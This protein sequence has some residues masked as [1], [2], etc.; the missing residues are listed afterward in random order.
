MAKNLPA[1]TKSRAVA[2]IS[3]SDWNARAKAAAAKAKAAVADI[4]GA[5]FLSFRG[6]VISYQQAPVPGNKLP[7][8]ILDFR[9][10]NAYYPGA[11]DP[12]NP[13]PPICYAIGEEPHE[14]VPADDSAKKQATSCDACPMNKFGSAEKGRGKACKNGIRIALVHADHLSTPQSMADANVVL[15]NIPPTSLPSFANYVNALDAMGKQPFQ[16]STQIGAAPDPKSQFKITF[17]LLGDIKNKAVRAPL[18]AK[19]DEAGP[20]LE[21]G[22]AAPS[23]D[24]GA[25]PARSRKRAAPEPSPGAFTRGAAKAAAKP[26]AAKPTGDKRGRAKF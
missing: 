25:E 20:L 5:Q 11:F 12:E 18:I 26:A 7:A 21:Q 8:V 23:D 24:D 4:G 16:V 9:R 14:M 15:A 1:T 22:F 17:E 2:T 10:V 13:Q 6:G 3:D 19:I